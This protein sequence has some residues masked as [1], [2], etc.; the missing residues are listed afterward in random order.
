MLEL[1]VL[2]EWCFRNIFFYSNLF[3]NIDLKTSKENERGPY[4]TN[5]IVEF[6]FYSPILVILANVV[7]GK[8]KLSSLNDYLVK[9]L[10][11]NSYN[12]L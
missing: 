2:D 6:P 12:L 4:S 10:A 8:L 11:V 7:L 1:K 5:V 3:F 9:Y